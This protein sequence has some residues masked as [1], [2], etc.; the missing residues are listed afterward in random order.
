MAVIGGTLSFTIDGIT[1]DTT[2][3]VT[4]EPGNFEGEAKVGHRGSVHRR[5]TF[6]A[7][8]FDST[9]MWT[10]EVRLLAIG[11]LNG[12]TC[13]WQMNNGLKYDFVGCAVEGRPSGDPIEGEI[14]LPMFA[15]KCIERT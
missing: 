15:E 11:A 4:L 5:E 13:T 10:P 2:G 8:R 7:P 1:Y 9:V 12:V 3:S 6:V 14:S